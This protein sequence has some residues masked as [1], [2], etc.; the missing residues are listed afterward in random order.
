MTEEVT[1]VPAPDIR[2]YADTDLV[3][4]DPDART[5]V[6]IVEW[7]EN[8]RPKSLV[9]PSKEPAG[10]E[11]AKSDRKRRLK[12]YPWG[13]YRSMKRLYKIEGK[14]R[15]ERPLISLDEAIAKAMQEPF[16]N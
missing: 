7:H 6:G 1:P 11:D 5:V 10:P 13:T 2:T 4:V 9:I 16:W 3:Y 14:M 8:G 15:E 12:Y